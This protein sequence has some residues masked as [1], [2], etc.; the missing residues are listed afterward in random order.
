M[1]FFVQIR[2][3]VVATLVAVA[4]AACGVGGYSRGIFQGN[5]VGKTVDEVIAQFGEPAS[6]DLSKPDA[7]KIVYLKKT[8]DPDNGNKED[9][10]TIISFR[11][12]GAKVVAYDLDFE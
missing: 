2:C 6:K 11:K 1:P 4:L 3:A 8:F 9:A 5:V 7:P 12:E 10:K